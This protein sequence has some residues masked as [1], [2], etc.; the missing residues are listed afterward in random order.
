MIENSELEE[1]HVIPRWLPINVAIES[2]MFARPGLVRSSQERERRRQ[3]TESNLLAQ[4]R[5]NR[6]AWRRGHELSDAEELVS[7]STVVGII[8]QDVAASAEQIIS[9]IDSLPRLRMLAERVLAR[10]LPVITK[11]RASL[12]SD[13]RS[14]IRIRK[15]LLEINPRDA[16]LVCELALCYANLGQVEQSEKHIRRAIALAPNSRYVIRSSARFFCHS[17]RPDEALWL[18]RRTPRHQTDPWLKAA[19]LAVSG[20]IGAKIND[21]RTARNLADNDSL[22][23]LDRSELASEIATLEFKSGSRKAALRKLQLA[24]SDPTEN[25]TAQLEFLHRKENSLAHD[26]ILPDISKSMEALALSNFWSGDLSKSFDA[27]EEWQKIEPFS[28][29]PAIFGSFLS[30]SKSNS[31]ERGLQIAKSGL[32]SNPRNSM[33]LNNLAVLCAYLGDIAEAKSYAVRARAAEDDK[34]VVA[35]RA[36]EG[37]LLFREGDIEGGIQSYNESI[38]LA[39]KEKR[40]DLLLRAYAFFAREMCRVE[41]TLRSEFRGEFERV[42]LSLRRRNIKMPRDVEIICDE[43]L[44]DASER[45]EPRLQWPRFREELLDGSIDQ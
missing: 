35:N 42:N 14:E 29:R 4:F 41:P 17:D 3:E 22:S 45:H 23:L 33:L 36:T 40:V 30:T 13:L 9:S 18:I 16:L 43:F 8:D 37:L 19:E 27:C 26:T 10:A 44:S 12:S 21:W 6:E 1:R 2:G 20:L 28:I 11:P 7:M 39:V 31:L 34:S 38:E 32:L 15:T 5:A 25:A 24:I